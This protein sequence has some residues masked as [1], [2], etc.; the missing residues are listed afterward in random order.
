[1]HRPIEQP[2]L[3]GTAGVLGVLEAHGPDAFVLLL[4]DDP[5]VVGHVVAGAFTERID[6]HVHR[7]PQREASRPHLVVF[8]PD[9]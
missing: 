1:M 9:Q 4:V 3:L 6:V 7:T 8:D 5:G 2:V